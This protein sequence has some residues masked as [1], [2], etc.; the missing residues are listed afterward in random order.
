MDFRPFEIPVRKSDKEYFENGDVLIINQNN[1]RYKG[2]VHIA[3]RPIRN[4]GSM[5][6]AGRIKEEEL[7]LLDQLKYFMNF[8]FIEV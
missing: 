2:E 4:D 6:Y 3:R 5:N 1:P 7:F 8:G